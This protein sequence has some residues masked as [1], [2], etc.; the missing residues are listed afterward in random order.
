MTKKYLQIL[1]PTVV[2]LIGI[3][4]ALTA[5]SVASFPIQAGSTAI[6][7]LTPTPTVSPEAATQAGSTDWITLMGVIIVLIVVIPVFFRRRAGTRQ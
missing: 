6:A 4:L 1:L 7:N 2:I 3:L 5:S